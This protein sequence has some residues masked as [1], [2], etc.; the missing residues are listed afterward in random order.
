MEIRV[1]VLDRTTARS[2]AQACSTPART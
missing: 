2:V 1:A